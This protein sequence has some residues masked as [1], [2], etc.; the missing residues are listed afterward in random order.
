MVIFKCTYTKKT[1]LNIVKHGMDLHVEGW[2][3]CLQNRQHISDD[4]NSF[5]DGDNEFIKGEKGIIDI[6]GITITNENEFTMDNVGG[7]NE[8]SSSN[9]PMERA[10]VC[11]DIYNARDHVE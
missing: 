5:N 4:G 6:G 10:I 3:P 11:L 8:N 2:L 7:S 9:V 1:L